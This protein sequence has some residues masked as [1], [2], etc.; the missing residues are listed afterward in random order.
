MENLE[1]MA[2][3]AVR[4]GYLE[5][6]M[7]ELRVKID[8]GEPPVPIREELKRCLDESVIIGEKLAV[9]YRARERVVARAKASRVKAVKEAA[10]ENAEL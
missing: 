6:R 5:M 8:A 4:Q 1:E 7:K 9:R 10:K 3:L 2:K